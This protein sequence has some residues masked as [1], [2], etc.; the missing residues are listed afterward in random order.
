MNDIASHERVRSIKLAPE[1]IKLSDPSV[2]N[3]PK[4]N[5]TFSIGAPDND[6]DNGFFSPFNAN[7]ASDVP[8]AGACDY[9][10]A[11]E[12]RDVKRRPVP[13]FQTVF[14]STADVFPS[15]PCSSWYV[16]L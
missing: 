12:S 3:G 5:L 7:P 10:E 4:S 16:M 2:R 14:R 13:G 15:L 9:G 6:K 1:N 11:D 8:E